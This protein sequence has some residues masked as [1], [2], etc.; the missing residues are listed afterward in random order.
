MDIDVLVLCWF[1]TTLLFP[2]LERVTGML[3]GVRYDAGKTFE[4]SVLAE[5]FDTL[6]SSGFGG[7]AF[8]QTLGLLEP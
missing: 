5:M 4:A 3:C 7:R 1:A 8:R 6:H 2:I